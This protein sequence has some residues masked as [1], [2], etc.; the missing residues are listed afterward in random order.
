MA[1]MTNKTYGAWRTIALALEFGNGAVGTLL[2]SYDSS[3][4]YPGTHQLE[5]N[6][7]AGRALALDT[8]RS[9]QLSRAG[10]EDTVMWQAGY[11]ND[12][13]RSFHNTVDRYVDDMLCAVRAG[14]PPPVPATAGRRALMI[15]LAAIESHHSGRRVT[16]SGQ[17]APV[18]PR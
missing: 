4:A 18:A 5:I 6:G 1:Q 16:V 10:S 3:Y 17:D 11:F 12:A 7:T 13:A 9:F 14:G 8:V 15:A 2:G